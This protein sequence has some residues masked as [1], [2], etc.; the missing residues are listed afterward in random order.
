MNVEEFERATEK[1]LRDKA[2][3]QFSKLETSGT[4][5]WAAHLLTAKFYMDEA[6]R[7]QHAKTEKRNRRLEHLA[8]ALEVVVIVLIGLELAG[9][10]K[11]LN[12]LNHLND[13]ADKTA[14]TMGLVQKAQEGTLQTLQ[15][16]LQP[17][18]DLLKRQQELISRQLA[19]QEASYADQ[20]RKTRNRV[21][22]AQP[23]KDWPHDSGIQGFS[24]SPDRL[25]IQTA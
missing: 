13:D 15:S 10:D 8:I 3:E 22:S 1:E 4:N 23:N 24:F 2:N 11:Q 9:S 17:Q 25:F 12:V 16:T 20:Q 6:E 21:E 5:D 18:V 14:T 19:I 7:R